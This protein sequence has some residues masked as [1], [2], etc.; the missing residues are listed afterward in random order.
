MR[1]PR[2]GWAR[3]P[4]PKKKPPRRTISIQATT[5]ARLKSVADAKGVSL[6]GMLE[7]WILKQL[8]AA[9][10]PEVTIE[11]V[12]PTKPRPRHTP[13]DDAEIVSQHFTF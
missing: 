11:D 2:S 7:A 12:P 9:G 6:S 4:K 10:V 13:P 1:S 3:M 5:Y 8:D